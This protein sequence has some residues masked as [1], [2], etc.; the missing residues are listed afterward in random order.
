VCVCVCACVC[1]RACV[2]VC[3]RAHAC[4]H[5][6]I[7]TLAAWFTSAPPSSSARTTSR[8]PSWAAMWSGVPPSCSCMRQPVEVHRISK[9]IWAWPMSDSSCIINACGMRPTVKKPLQL[10]WTEKQPLFDFRLWFR[11]PRHTAA[12]CQDSAGSFSGH[13]SLKESWT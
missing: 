7:C 13:L 12:S 2:C 5:L 6:A 3:A 10:S 4:P 9:P 1:A 11:E 8:W